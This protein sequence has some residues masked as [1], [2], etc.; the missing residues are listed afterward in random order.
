MKKIK[1]PGAPPPKGKCG[2]RPPLVGSVNPM[3][4]C[5]F[6]KGHKGKHSWQK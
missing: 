1:A 5:G 2:A 4:M 3:L 6:Q